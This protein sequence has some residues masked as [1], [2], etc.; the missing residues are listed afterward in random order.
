MI[1]GLLEPERPLDQHAMIAGE[2]D[3]AGVPEEVRGVEEVHMQGVALDPLAAVQQPAQGRDR[4]VD[5]DAGRVLER[6]DGAHLVGDRADPADARDDVQDLVRRPAANQPFEV[7]WCLEDPEVRL[8]D[9][10][11]LDDQPERAL[12]FHAGETLDLEALGLRPAPGGR[13]HRRASMSAGD[14]GGCRA[15]RA[16][17]GIHDGAEGLR[18]DREPGEPGGDVGVREARGAGDQTGHVGVSARAEAA[19]AAAPVGRA[20]RAAAGPGDRTETGDPGRD[21]DAGRAAALAFR[22]DRF[23]RELRSPADDEGRQELEQLA[24]VD[25]AA[26]QLGVHDHVV[27]DGRRHR[28]RIHELRLRVDGGRPRSMVG[29]VPD[30][31][32]PSR[33]RACPDRHEGGRLAAKAEQAP[34]AAR[35]C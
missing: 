20:Q 30:G 34:R 23:V 1:A 21:D 13:R 6:V 2:L 5:L 24:R 3:R 35:P 32:D 22:A 7:A 12:A 33:G 18:P 11:V 16:A 15:G 14:G 25:R 19:V 8:D 26:T 28:Q 31:L 27:G 29:P 4:R 9:V 17:V 10:A